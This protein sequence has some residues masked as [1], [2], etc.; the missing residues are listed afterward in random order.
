MATNKKLLNKIYKILRLLK[1]NVQIWS[2]ASNLPFI[3]SIILLIPFIDSRGHT[4]GRC[5]MC[6]HTIKFCL[7]RFIQGRTEEFL[8]TESKSV[9]GPSTSVLGRCLHWVSVV[10]RRKLKSCLISEE[11][12]TIKVPGLWIMCMQD[13]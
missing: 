12:K 3:D 9:S 10:R 1:L 13:M 8:H 5:T 11:V 7:R 4:Q 2:F 6:I